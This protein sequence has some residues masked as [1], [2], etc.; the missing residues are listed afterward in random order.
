MCPLP[1][2]ISCHFA[3]SRCAYI[4]VEGTSQQIIAD[5]IEEVVKKKLGRDSQVTFQVRPT[6]I[7]ILLLVVFLC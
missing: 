5:E 2:A 6:M 3:S 7:L 1:Q 4:D